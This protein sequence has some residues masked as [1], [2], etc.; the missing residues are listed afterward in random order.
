MPVYRYGNNYV[1]TD[2]SGKPTGATD[3]FGRQINIP[4]GFSVNGKAVK[5]VIFGWPD[6]IDNG[7]GLS[8]FE[9]APPL[10]TDA[11]RAAQTL[12]GNPV[13]QGYANAGYGQGTGLTGGSRSGAGGQ[14]PIPGEGSSGGGTPRGSGD[15]P[16]TT[17]H[18]SQPLPGGVLNLD[19]EN[20]LQ[21]MFGGGDTLVRR[22]PRLGSPYRDNISQQ[23]A[24]LSF[25]PGLFNSQG[26]SASNFAVRNAGANAFGIQRQQAQGQIGK[27]RGNL[28]F[29]LVNDLQRNQD[30]SDNDLLKALLGYRTG[31]NQL[32]QA[33]EHFDRSL[34]Q[35]SSEFDR[36]LTNTRGERKR[37]RADSYVDAFLG[38]LAAGLPLLLGRN[39]STVRGGYQT[40]GGGP[41]IN[42]G[43]PGFG[44]VPGLNGP[45]F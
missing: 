27:Q 35:R 11:E 30:L 39:N 28:F 13:G 9:N 21:I 10:R 33:G 22:P 29:G 23:A 16:G 32:E 2:A 12:E 38:L 6:P 24:R 45:L 18:G 3:L 19:P 44:S 34:E 42:L 26:D 7:T 36:S 37:N 15:L 41:N 14:V 31:Q 4:A 43:Q 8:G 5:E 25:L 1:H 17:S 40:P 20:L